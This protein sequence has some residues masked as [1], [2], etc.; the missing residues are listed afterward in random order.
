[1][2]KIA[3]LL[4]VVAFS[5]YSCYN[6]YRISMDDLAKV[7]TPEAGTRIAVATDEAEKVVV[8]PNTLLFVREMGGKRYPITPYNFTI[9]PSKQLVASDRDYIFMMNQLEPKAEVDLLSTGKTVALI[10]AGVGAVAGLIVVT[11][12]TA[13]RKS[14]GSGN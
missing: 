10:A 1:M 9:T 7:Q 14:F 3:A 13:G 4:L 6:T 11:A 2:K 12:A 8:E 5:S